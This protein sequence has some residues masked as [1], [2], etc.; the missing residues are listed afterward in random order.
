MPD[1]NQKNKKPLKDAD[2][3]RYFHVAF[4]ALN[5]FGVPTHGSLAFTCEGMFNRYRFAERIKEDYN[6]KSMIITGW[7]YFKTKSD[8]DAFV[9]KNPPE[10]SLSAP[11]RWFNVGFLASSVGGTNA[12]ASAAFGADNM[13]NHDKFCSDTRDNL[14]GDQYKLSIMD[15]SISNWFEF[16]NKED[17][18]NFKASI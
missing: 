16:E 18:D 15:I 12:S 5:N 9:A 17:Y 14:S 10:E 2:D 13:F 7:Q 4:D 1:A 8:Y 3:T 6:Y 11:T